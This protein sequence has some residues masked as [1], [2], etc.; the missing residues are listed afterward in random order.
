MVSFVR[1]KVG[2]WTNEGHLHPIDYKEK[3]V[4]GHRKCQ[5]GLRSGQEQT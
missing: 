4:T 1:L 5:K 2:P 3:S